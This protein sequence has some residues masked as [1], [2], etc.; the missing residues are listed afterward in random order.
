VRVCFRCSHSIGKVLTLAAWVA[1]LAVVALPAKK[2][3]EDE[4]QVLQYPKELPAAVAGD[5]RRLAFPVT[6]LSAKGLLSQQVRDA[7]KNLE[8]QAAGNPVVSIR[9]FVAGSGD[10]RRVR[11]LVSETFT[12]KHQPLPALSLIQAGGLP[13]NGAQVVLEAVVNGRKDLYPGGLAF[14][15][16]QSV[17]SEDPLAP[18]GPLLDRTLAALHTAVQ[19]AGLAAADVLRITCFFSTLDSFAAA[20]GRIEAEYPRVAQ[21]YVQ[22][23]RAPQRAVAACEAIGGIR[24][25]PLPSPGVEF[26]D[27]PGA[28]N[29]RFRIALVRAQQV[30]FTGTQVSFGREDQDAR[31]AFDRLGKTLEPLGVTLGDVVWAHF[32]PLSRRSEQQ[33]RRQF[34]AFFGQAKLPAISLLEFEGLSSADAGFAVDAVAAK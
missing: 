26:R 21:D 16:A 24:E 3:K 29:E 25:S 4:T 12:E 7:L 34:P 9:A 28:A 10:L 23:E 8:H 27:V 30:V 31:L 15:P 1:V 14:F 2:K 13:L 6:P 22:T 33:I 18:V 5:T 19:S 17:F 20:R 11:D 32:Y